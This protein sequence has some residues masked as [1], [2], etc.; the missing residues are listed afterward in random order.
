MDMFNSPLQAPRH[1]NSSPLYSNI[2]FNLLGIALSKV[3]SKPYEDVIADLIFNPL[4]MSQSTFDTPR[5]DN[6]NV[7]LPAQGD[8]WDSYPFGN[9]NPT[10]G[11]WTN[12]ADLSKFLR[13]ILQ[14]KLLSPA[15][16]RKWLQPVSTTYNLRRL[17][18]APWEIFRKGEALARNVDIYQKSGNVQGYAGYAVIVPE[19]DLAMTVNMAGNSSAKA[20]H[21]AIYRLTEAIIER[22]D[23]LTFNAMQSKYVG[24]YETGCDGPISTN[25][26]CHR[27]KLRLRVGNHIEF[28]SFALE[29]WHA[30]L[31]NNDIIDRLAH[32]YGLLP[33]QYLDPTQ[34]DIHTDARLQPIDLD[35]PVD[36]KE[37]WR[38]HMN[39]RVDKWKHPFEEEPLDHP[40]WMRLD[41]FRYGGRSLDEWKFVMEDGKPVALEL[42][43]WN[44]TLPK[45]NRTLE[46]PSWGSL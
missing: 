37:S 11:I 8:K 35:G 42:P 9:F 39:L 44:L 36:G 46:F 22:V 4:E 45:T 31:D 18:G 3:H 26:G 25:A 2:G 27:I 28:Q 13:A 30:T 7:F 15:E 24:I 21:E 12:A 5:D 19:F 10:G 40:A 43:A 23:N 14:H 38:L 1:P 34:D 17:V 20:A 29:V 32:L 41:K 33:A 6:G 16:T